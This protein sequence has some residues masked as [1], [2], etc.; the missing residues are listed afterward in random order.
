M[1]EQIQEQ[2]QLPL[3]GIGPRL[4]AAREAKGLSRNDIA[5]QTRISERV[6]A[7]IEDGRFDKLP[8]RAYVV[9]F[10]RSYARLVGIGEGEAIAAVREELGYAS[11][12]PTSRHSAALEPGDPARVPTARFAWLLALLALA[13]IAAGLFFWRTYYTPAMSLPPLPEESAVPSDGAVTTEA[14]APAFAPT[15]DPQV[16]ISPT[17]EPLAPLPAPSPRTAPHAA[18]TRASGPSPRPSA[19]ATPAAPAPGASTVPN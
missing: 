11:P 5:R 16:T 2:P 9:G 4:K 6:I 14:V 7:D 1:S 8:S 18:S 10:V 15:L 13:V 12:Q 3:T 19:T 17:G